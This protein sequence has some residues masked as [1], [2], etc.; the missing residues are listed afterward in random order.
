[1]F[2]SGRRCQRRSL[3]WLRRT[4][5]KLKPSA[6]QVCNSWSYNFGWTHENWESSKLERERW[7]L[8]QWCRWV[9]D[10]ILSS[11]SAF[12][13]KICNSILIISWG[14]RACILNYDQEMALPHRWCGPTPTS[15]FT[16]HFLKR[17]QVSQKIIEMIKQNI[18]SG[19]HDN[20]IFEIIN[21]SH[22][23]RV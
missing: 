11:T 17:R 5:E 12:N 10:S 23:F 8:G 15:L 18:A 1:M 2:K 4:H 9:T 21:V 14:G 20:I 3:I 16:K 22:L 19:C 7:S 13:F 6:N